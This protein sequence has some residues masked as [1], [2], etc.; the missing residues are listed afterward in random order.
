MCAVLPPHYQTPQI[1]GLNI[2]IPYATNM[3]GRNFSCYIMLITSR[4]TGY[5]G[6]VTKPRAREFTEKEEV[7]YDV[8]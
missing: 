6:K 2:L 7:V 1:T 8:Y 4:S 5:T 3:A